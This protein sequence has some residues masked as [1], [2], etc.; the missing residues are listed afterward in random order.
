MP[1]SDAKIRAAQ[2]GAQLVKPSD[3]G[4]LQ[5]W[6]TPD[7]AKRWRLATGSRARKRRWR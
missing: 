3:G 2:T 4:G 7:G 1:L 6:V 5:F